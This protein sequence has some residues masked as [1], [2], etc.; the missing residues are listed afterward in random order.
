[1]HQTLVWAGTSI[2]QEAVEYCHAHN[3][4]VIARACP[5]MYVHSADLGHRCM[6]WIF[7]LTS[8]LQRQAGPESCPRAVCSLLD[9]LVA[10]AVQEVAPLPWRKP[11]PRTSAGLCFVDTGA[12]GWC[13]Y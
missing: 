11:H 5:M 12:S 6:Q 7:G 13:S 3:I 1:M 4:S 8:G 9:A 2:S 10:P